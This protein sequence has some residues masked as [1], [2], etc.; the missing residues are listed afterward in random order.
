M[1][2]KTI[3]GRP[4]TQNISKYLVKWDGPSLSKVQFSTKQFLKNF[5]STHLVTEE[6]TIPASRLRCDFLNYTKMIAVEVDGKFHND[7]SIF[8]HGHKNGFLDSVRRDLKKENWIE[9]IMGFTLIR[10]GEDDVK[11]LTRQWIIDNY[12]LDLI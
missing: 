7:F 8:H 2:I 1:K 9:N 3:D 12:N 5:W 4:F 10:I 11:K 6:Q